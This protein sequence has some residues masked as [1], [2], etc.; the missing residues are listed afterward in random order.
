[1]TKE[2]SDEIKSEIREVI[3]TVEDR[4]ESSDMGSSDMQTLCGLS[5]V[6]RCDDD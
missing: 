1:V 2:I 4:L 6:N 3:S 5:S